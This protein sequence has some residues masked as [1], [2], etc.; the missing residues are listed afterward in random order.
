MPVVI[1]RD[2]VA[3]GDDADAPH[4]WVLSVPPDGT[5]GDVVDAIVRARYLASIA[6]GRATWIVEGAQPIAVV[7]QQWTAPRW[8]VAPDSPVAA[9]RRP[10]GSPDFEVRYWCQVDPERVYE[11]LRT[12]APLPDRYG[13]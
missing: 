6:G 5:V 9:A 3:A 1:W 7:A 8:L 13:R 4:E 11:S 2:S 12:G 10:T